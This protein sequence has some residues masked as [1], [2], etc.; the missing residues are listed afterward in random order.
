[1]GGGGGLLGGITNTLFGS[2]QTVATPNYTQAAQQT[3]ASN[4][5]NAQ[6]GNAAQQQGFTQASYNQMQ[7]INVI[8]A[9]RTGTQVN[10]ANYVNPVQQANPGGADLLSATQAGYQAQLGQ[11]NANQAANAGFF[12]GL[13]GLGGLG[14]KAYGAG[15][16]G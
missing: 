8:N 4:L 11:Y 10:P 2:P 12:G 13:M 16:F 1:M 9:L 6:L 14:V 3:A 7:P 5:Q 15:L